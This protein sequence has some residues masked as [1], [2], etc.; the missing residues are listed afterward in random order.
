MSWWRRR[1]EISCVTPYSNDADEQYLNCDLRIRKVRESQGRSI[2]SKETE[3]LL[4]IDRSHLD[5]F[6]FAIVSRTAGVLHAGR[7]SIPGISPGEFKEMLRTE[8]DF[9][10][11]LKRHPDMSVETLGEVLR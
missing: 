5:R 2:R 6:A 8:T 11:I 4:D 3:D 1:I 9:K 10:E 7:A